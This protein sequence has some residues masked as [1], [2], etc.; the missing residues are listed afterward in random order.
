LSDDHS[1]TEWTIHLQAGDALAA[2]EF[3]QR[4]VDQLVRL[5]RR[6]LG[7]VARRV[8]DEED[9]VIS[10]FDAAFRG[11]REGRFSKLDDRHELWQ[12]LAMLTERKAIGSK[13]RSGALRRGRGLIRGESAFLK[14]AGNTSHVG[15][16]SQFAGQKCAAEFAAAA[17]DQL[18]HLLGSLRDASLREIAFGKLAGYTNCELS[19]RLG[20]TLR[21]V[22]RK[23]SLIRREWE[24]RVLS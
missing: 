6:K 19:D 5:A 2:Q 18:S 4:F 9:V 21:A 8:A 14:R 16:L 22:E 12:I 1:I 13:R 11:I 15:G 3:W 20:L 23:L 10:V 7:G 24:S 17:G